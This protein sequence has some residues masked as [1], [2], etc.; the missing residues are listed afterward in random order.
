MIVTGRVVDFAL[1]ESKEATLARIEPLLKERAEAEGTDDVP[2]K[3]RLEELSK[4]ANDSLITLHR[5]ADGSKVVRFTEYISNEGRFSYTSGGFNGVK[6]MLREV[7]IALFQG[8]W[9]V[10]LKRCHTSMLLGGY[11][12]AASLGTAPKHPLLERMRTALSTVEE[13]LAADQVR[14]TPKAEV[15]LDNSR[16]TKDEKNA[17]RFV[18]YLKSK[19]KTLLSAMLNHP[20][21]SPMFKSWPLAASC[22]RALGAAAAASRSHPL[23]DADQHRP[24]VCHIARGS[25]KEK[26]RIAFVLERRAVAAL[27]IWLEANGMMP[28][29]TVNDE[30]LFFP[31]GT[32]DSEKLECSL[33]SEVE[34]VLG[35]EAPLCVESL[36]P[37]HA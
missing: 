1:T 26:Q 5:L 12:R 10:D 31:P 2:S 27:V 33:A 3:R 9:R 17:E 21:D 36:S 14:L 24:E 23:V 13:E 35:F 37:P 28:S 20:N 29:L 18:G 8:A 19:P 11:G 4:K 16:G 32:V 34:R 15:R 7:R 22:C 6:S 30:V 25:A